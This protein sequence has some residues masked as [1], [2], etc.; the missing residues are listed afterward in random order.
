M[1]LALLPLLLVNAINN[2]F[3]FI[4]LLVYSVYFSFFSFDCL[5]NFYVIVSFCLVCNYCCLLICFLENKA[6]PPTV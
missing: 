6:N 2:D 1:A 5:L 3:P 4:D